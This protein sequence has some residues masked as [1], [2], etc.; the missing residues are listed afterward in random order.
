MIESI[1]IP[2]DR[3][4]VLIGSRGKTK[5][6]IEKNTNTKIGMGDE[7]LIEGEYLDVLKALNV[8]KAIGRG[9]SPENAFILFSDKYTLDVISLK[10]TKD[11]IKRL[12]SRVIGYGGKARK[13]IE[14]RTDV[15]ISIYGR[16]ISIIGEYKPVSLARKS[17]EM[18][19][20]GRTHNYVYRM[21]ERRPQ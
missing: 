5:E 8:V 9:F 10:G 11:N 16:T 13:N 14:V 18:L 6:E 20:S 17:I 15:K 21:L 1:K 7:V 12:E 3:L 4:G 19:L 2:E